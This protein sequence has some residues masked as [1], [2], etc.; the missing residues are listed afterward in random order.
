M[1]IDISPLDLA[2][3]ERGERRLA[4]NHKGGGAMN[5]I[6]DTEDQLLH[7]Y[8][9]RYDRPFAYEGGIIM[10]KAGCFTRDMATVGFDIDHNP[11][12]RV[13]TTKDALTITD[14]TDGL[15][16]HVDLGKAKLGAMLGSM[17]SKRNRPCT[18]IGC[19]ILSEHN[20]QIAGHKVRVVTRAKLK[21]ISLVRRGAAEDAFAAVTTKMDGG[22][23]SPM[24][25]LDHKLHRI[26]TAAED[27]R[28]RLAPFVAPAR[29]YTVDVSNRWQTEETERLQHEALVRRLFY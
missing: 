19:T 17:A 26:L 7:G 25:A 8:A 27:V 22:S 16:F 18:S 15:R 4:R 20:G 3:L 12:T 21:E 13:A 5:A 28:A 14:D 24:F 2:I 10:F 29:S 9:L 23:S 6:F 11:D 1:T